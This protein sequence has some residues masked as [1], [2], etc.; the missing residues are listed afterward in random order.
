MSKFTKREYKNIAKRKAER[1]YGF[2]RNR[3]TIVANEAPAE[4]KGFLPD[5]LIVDDPIDWQE[6]LTDLGEQE[7]LAELDNNYNAKEEDYHG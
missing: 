3:V 4:L 5:L 7:R 2:A 6:T 1:G